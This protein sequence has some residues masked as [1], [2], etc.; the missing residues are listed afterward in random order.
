MAFQSFGQPQR[1]ETGREPNRGV[2]GER[3][4]QR[5]SAPFDLRVFGQ[6]ERFQA[7]VETLARRR[8]DP[9]QPDSGDLFA[10]AEANAPEKF[11]VHFLPPP[12]ADALC[13]SHRFCL[14]G[15]DNTSSRGW[16]IRFITF[17]YT[18]FVW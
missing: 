13:F 11:P 8:R 2:R 3:G 9:V 15:E 5:V 7:G 1:F 12:P 17:C 4:V 6:S 18:F 10:L 14:W 16:C